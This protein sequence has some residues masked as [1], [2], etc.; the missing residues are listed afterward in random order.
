MYSG[1]A[2]HSLS[3]ELFATWAVPGTSRSIPEAVSG[4]PSLSA[5][6]YSAWRVSAGMAGHSRPFPPTPPHADRLR[7]SLPGK[8]FRGSEIL[9]VRAVADEL[10]GGAEL[11]DAPYPL[12]PLAE[13]QRRQAA[14]RLLGSSVPPWAFG[15]RWST[16]RA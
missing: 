7:R 1:G 13:L 4:S 11:G 10:A 8:Y 15:S 12:A 16:V 2:Y 3:P 5:L 9:S 6:A 14:T